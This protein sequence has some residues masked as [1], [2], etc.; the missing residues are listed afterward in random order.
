M[1]CHDLATFILIVVLCQ[2]VSPSNSVPELSTLLQELRSPASTDAAR[3]ALA[4]I[5]TSVEVQHSVALQLDRVLDS[6]SDQKVF[7]SELMLIGDLRLKELAPKLA[8][9]LEK[10]GVSGAVTAS[11]MASLQD[12]PIGFTLS[13]LGDPAV[14]ALVPLLKGDRRSVRLRAF[15]IMRR[16]DTPE[17]HKALEE[18]QITETDPAMLRLLRTTPVSKGKAVLDPK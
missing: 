16:I 5:A 18:L 3:A 15:Y 17:S 4:K 2:G 11:G 9:L 8:S 12:D 13:R 1:T 10:R 7:S 14:H 6:E